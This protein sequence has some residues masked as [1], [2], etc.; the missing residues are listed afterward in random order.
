MNLKELE[1]ALIRARA[2]GA[3][4]E[5]RVLLASGTYS[6]DITG[7]WFNVDAPEPRR[8]VPHDEE[9]MPNDV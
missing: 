5:D 7:L 6:T 3:Q 9:P 8:L 1:E 2:K 4:G